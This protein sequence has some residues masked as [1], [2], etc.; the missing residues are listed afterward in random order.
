MNINELVQQ[1]YL[2][3]MQISALTD[4]LHG[5]HQQIA[6]SADYRDGSKTGHI[7]TP[8]FKITVSQ[9]ENVKWNTDKL[10]S[11][12]NYFGDKFDS[13][14]K[15]EI[16]PDIRKIKATGGEIEKAFLWAKESTAGQPQVTYEMITEEEAA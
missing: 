13:L 3:K 2:I 7:H 10:M 5:I 1:G 8:D 9:R 14:V 6:D 16:K 15:Y 4:K 11:V 12:K